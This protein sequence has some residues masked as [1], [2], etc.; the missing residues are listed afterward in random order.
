MLLKRFVYYIQRK[1]YAV[2][3]VSP[4][5]F[6]AYLVILLLQL[7]SDCMYI[8]DGVHVEFPDSDGKFCTD[9]FDSL[10]SLTVHA[11][12]ND[13]VTDSQELHGLPPSTTQLFSSSASTPTAGV[14]GSA[15]GSSGF[16][17]SHRQRW[18]PNISNKGKGN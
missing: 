7:N 15:S 4:Y 11:T 9:N 5:Q 12:V 16:K 13:T 10:D 8:S 6:S 3:R 1:L 17:T 14:I 2:L 18:M